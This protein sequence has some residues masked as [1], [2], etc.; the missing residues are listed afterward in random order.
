MRI[1]VLHSRYLSGPVSGENRAVD[2]QV[3]LLRQAGHSVCVWQP[4]PESGSAAA[5]LR[6][7]AGAVWSRGATA[8]VRRRIAVARPAVIHSH[9]L[10]PA[11]SPAVLRL[12]G[13]EGIPTVVTLHNYRL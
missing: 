1:L 5:L 3:E 11:L 2:D 6:T 12:A 7:G 9:N 4:V 13:E 10:F 8:E